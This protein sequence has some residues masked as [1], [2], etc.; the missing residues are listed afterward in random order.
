MTSKANTARPRTWEIVHMPDIAVVAGRDRAGIVD[1]RNASNAHAKAAS[2]GVN[3]SGRPRA[4]RDRIADQP[5]SRR[6]WP[7]G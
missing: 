3:V 4:A 5:K 1:R 6:K 7:S 2:D